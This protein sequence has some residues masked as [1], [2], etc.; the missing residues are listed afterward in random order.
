VLI[1]RHAPGLEVDTVLIDNVDSAYRIIAHLLGHGRRRIGALF[2]VGSTTGRERREGYE[3]ALRDHGIEAQ[4]ELASNVAAREEAGF[5]QT[6]R[7]L[8]LP[9]PPD[10]V[11]ASNGLLSAGAFRAIRE[12]GLAVPDQLAFAAFDKT[13]WTSLVEPAIT[14]IEQPTYEIGQVATELLL[15]RIQDRSRPIREVI[16]KGRLLVRRSCGCP[17]PCAC[18]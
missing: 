5:Q 6:L 17:A 1:D 9:E 8:D 11:F 3:R 12:R 4:A 18:Q 2:G 14:V 7:L 13:T 15:K 16:L 10:A